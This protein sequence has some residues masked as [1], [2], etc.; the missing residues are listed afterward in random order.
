MKL[1]YTKT[2]PALTGS[3]F[4]DSAPDN[5]LTTCPMYLPGSSSSLGAEWA[6]VSG[7]ETDQPTVSST[8]VAP[9]NGGTTMGQCLWSYP[10]LGA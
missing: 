9:Y 4:P 10:W 2:H 5:P 6:E 7:L 1:N 8:Y 3:L